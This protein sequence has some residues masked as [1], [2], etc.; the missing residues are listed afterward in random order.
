MTEEQLDDLRF[1][2]GGDWYDTWWCSAFDWIT[3]FSENQ[4]KWLMK[5]WREDFFDGINAG[6]YEMYGVTDD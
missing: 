2:L 3:L 4:S 6:W 1:K 5:E